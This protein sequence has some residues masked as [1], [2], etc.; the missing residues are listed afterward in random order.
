VS[1]VRSVLIVGGGVIGCSLARELAG[2]GVAVTV[3]E[4]AEPGAEASSAAAG[5]IA[6]QAEGLPPGPLFDLAIAGR[7]LYPGWSEDLER[8][9]S[10]DV[11]W[12]RT[13]I[14][15]C[16]LS[17]CEDFS[18]YLRQRDA[19]LPVEE[20]DASRIAE[21]T[22]GLSCPEATRGVFFPEDGTV[23]AKRLTRALWLAAQSRGA[24]FVN[25][26]AARRFVVAEGRCR[27]V[28]TDRGT[29]EADCVV[30]AA[31]AWAA[32]DAEAPVPVSPVRGQIVRLRPAEPLLPCVVESEDVYLVPRPD[33]SLLV[34]ST[35]ER[36]GFRKEVTGQGVRGLLDAAL[37]LVPS[38]ADARF[39]GAWAG[40]RP[41]SPDGWPI[42]G[43]SAIPGLLFATGHFR[44]G[45]LLAP[46]TAT[47][48]ADAALGAAP[49]ELVPFSAARFRPPEENRRLH[50]EER[51]FG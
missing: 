33:G 28:E 8:E 15:R 50:Q 51:V 2:R 35:Q 3:V 30:D 19:G 6:P 25:G 13:G 7:A 48:L 29:F 40:L 44:N 24:R 34:G 23:D 26:A 17:G 46:I 36:V 18:R 47:L 10:I 42:L 41:A 12:R 38:L 43:A 37:T 1:S 20:A 45:I 22:A 11:G 9:T 27:A 32:F 49:R 14:L 39:V 31:G 5:L 21:L 16:D 4:R